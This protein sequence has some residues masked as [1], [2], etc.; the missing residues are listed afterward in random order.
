MIYI[1]EIWEIVIFKLIRH[2]FSVRLL[3]MAVSRKTTTS[4]SSSP[5]IR[6]SIQVFLVLI[7]NQIHRNFG[8]PVFT[9]NPSVAQCKYADSWW[10]FFSRRQKKNSSNQTKITVIESKWER[11]KN[12]NVFNKKKEHG[13]R[14]VCR[15]EEREKLF[16][17]IENGSHSIFI[18]LCVWF[19]WRI[20][21]LDSSVICRNILLL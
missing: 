13:R 8:S 16:E 7:L 4:S 1:T 2:F 6:W 11:K 19:R 18:A 21:Y 17:S 20:F 9:Y 12:T 3:Q 5:A 14:K 15:W 10:V